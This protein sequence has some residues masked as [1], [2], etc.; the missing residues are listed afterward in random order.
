MEL[1]LPRYRRETTFDHVT[2]HLKD[3]NG[4]P[5]V[6][7]HENPIL[8]TRVYEVEYADGHK[9]SMETNAITTNMFAQVDA[10]G[11]RQALFDEIADHRTDG[12]EIKQQDACITAKNG[13]RRRR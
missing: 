9:A 10:E 7:S 8:D 5:I 3:T 2:K 12:K 11:N 1:G 13:I 6:T 4:L